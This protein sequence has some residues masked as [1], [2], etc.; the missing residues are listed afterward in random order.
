MPDPNPGDASS[1]TTQ[2]L[3]RAR[4]GE[5][6]AL[7]LVAARLHPLVLAMARRRLG[8][9][10]AAATQVTPEDVAQDVW[11]IAWSRLA[12][13]PERDGR[14][15][16]VILRFLSTTL[17]NRLR[18][19]SRARA[20]RTPATPLSGALFGLSDGA[21]RVPSRVEATE[22][23]ALVFAALDSLD[24]PDR[25]LIYL[26]GIEGHAYRELVALL[27]AE[28]NALTQRYRRALARLREK[29]PS[30]VFDELD[31]E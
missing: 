14:S 23:Q 29:V 21:T 8:A 12:E 27:G 17:H 13:L 28:E 3:R 6:A 2:L 11:A 4:S 24:A 26:R 25:E 9:G 22:R 18:E 7:D 1:L 16:P 15:T 19:L 5:A 31:P 20:R 30:S 10:L